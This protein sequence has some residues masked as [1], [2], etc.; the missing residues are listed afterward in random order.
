MS[1]TPNIPPNAPPSNEGYVYE[2]APTPRWIPLVIFVLFLGIGALVY[3]GYNSRVQL[4]Y[5]LAQSNSH[6]D[7]LSKELERTNSRIAML[8]GQVDVT[9]QKLGLTQAE[10]ARARSLA[11]QIE[12]EQQESD[13]KLM[14]QIGQVQ[15]ES[16]AKFGQVSTDLTGAKSDI[17]ATKKDLDETKKSL[18]TAVGDLNGQG[19][20]IARNHEELDDLKR[21]NERNIYDFKLTKSKQPQHVGPIQILLRSTDPKHYKFTMTVIADDKSIEKKD[22][23]VDE[24]MQLYVHGVRAPYEMVVFEVTKDGANGYLS[25]PKETGAPAPAGAGASSGA[26]PPANAP[27]AA[28]PPPSAPAAANAPSGPP[29]SQ[30]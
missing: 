3:V 10:L 6:A 14:A 19:V 24:P 2:Q 27:A 15:K 30:Q 23:N 7:V 25:T 17:A 5:A 9:S 22:R 13:A 29:R 16:D 8:R 26:T 21:L 12:Q 28:A 11:Q 18:T 1:I 20:L 4:Q